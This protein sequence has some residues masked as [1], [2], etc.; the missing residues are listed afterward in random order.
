MRGMSIGQASTDNP[1][2]TMIL[3]MNDQVSITERRVT[4]LLDA[5]S[6]T[7]GLV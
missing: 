1:C 4:T 7:G 3:G 5:L 6:S 2:F